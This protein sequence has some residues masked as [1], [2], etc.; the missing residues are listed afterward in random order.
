MADPPPIRLLL[1]EDNPP[2]R[3]LVEITL[4][5]GLAGDHTLES[6]ESLAPALA[7][8][9][10][11]D[12]SG[13]DLVL[14]DL[15]LPDCSGLDSLRR[16]RK[17]DQD[18]PVVVLSGQDEK[19]L[20][21]AAVSE[22]ADDYVLKG[23]FD[24]DSLVRAVRFAMERSQRFRAE[25]EL[26]AAQSQL[27]LAH[28]VQ[29]ELLPKTMPQLVGFDIGGAMLPAEFAGGDFFD[30]IDVETGA[31]TIALGDVAGH[32]CA[33]AMRMVEAH[34]CLRAFSR[35]CSD[36]ETIVQETNKVLVARDHQISQFATLFLG[37]LESNRRSL[38]YV[39]AGHPGFVLHESGSVTKLGS[40]TLPLGLLDSL[41]VDGPDSLPLDAGDIVLLPTDGIWEAH[42]TSGTLF[43]YDRMMETVR[44]NRDKPAQEI[45]EA[46][47]NAVSDFLQDAPQNDD[48]AAVVIKTCRTSE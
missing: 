17:A 4:A 14:L 39:S 30:F 40:N 11:R 16:V 26:Y 27:A 34:T 36:L 42:V 29:Q 38:E 37:G 28:S 48:M 33:A 2:D 24:E 23:S 25:R 45:V 8:L 9:E 3:K 31:L 6:F 10:H 20:A 32:G 44:A 22:G 15:Q 41:N 43:G 12:E 7:Q 47:F 1:V 35:T 13:F 21:L 5:A 18:M 46:L 19:G